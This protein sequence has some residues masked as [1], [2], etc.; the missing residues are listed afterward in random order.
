MSEATNASFP[1]NIYE[2]VL[3]E[4]TICD[5]SSQ[6]LDTTPKIE[7]KILCVLYLQNNKIKTL[8]DDFFPS[9]PSLMYLDLRDNQL[10]DIPKTI[11]NHPTLTH[12]LLQ[13]NKL[14]SLPYELG[15]VATLKVLQLNGN[16]L[17]FP[18]REIL[19]AGFSKVKIFLHDKFIENMFEKTQ[20]VLSEDTRSN[21]DENTSYG[22]DVVS[23]NSV[24]D[25]E[26]LKNLTIQ[27]NEKDSEDSDEEYYGKVKGKCPKLAKSRHMT[28]PTHFQSAKYLRP[29]CVDTDDE[30]YE[31]AKQ[32]HL[33]DLAIKKH[34]E[35]LAT[36]IER[37]LPD[38]YRK[39]LIRKCKPIAPRKSNNDVHLALKIK[40]LFENLEAIDLNREGMT[41]RTEQKVL[42][43]EIHK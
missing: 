24:I 31:R 33:K 36:N 11:Q 28:L 13:N 1:L 23:Y 40:Q 17:T 30:H 8:P 4:E 43:N 16:P 35:F 10:T 27:F 19:N 18:P 12:L 39:K 32:A 29:L 42:M 7:N 5:C 3:N 15:S 2:E 22:H 14:T 37:D 20:S 34:K 9:L 6:G 26:K 21:F 41:P 25:G 38:K